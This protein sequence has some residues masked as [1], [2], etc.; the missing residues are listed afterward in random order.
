MGPVVSVQIKNFSGDR[1]ELAKVLGADDETKSH[2]TL[3]TPWNLAS[4]VRNYH[5]IIVRRHHTD[6]KQMGL[7]EQLATVKEGASAVLLLSGL[8]EKWRADS[9]ECYTYLRN[10][11]DLVLMGRHHMRDVWGNHLRTSNIVWSNG[12]NITPFLRRTYRDYINLVQKSCQVS[13]S[14]MYCMRGESGKETP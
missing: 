1:K 9:M 11:Q 14:V 10:I 5:G 4:L 8:D 6:Q 7:R 12:S 2:F 13:S 3:T